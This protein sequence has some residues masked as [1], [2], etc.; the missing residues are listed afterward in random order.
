MNKFLDFISSKNFR[1]T[2]CFIV[3]TLIMAITISSQNYLFQKVLKNGMFTA[4]ISAKRDMKVIDV[5]KTEQ[6]KKKAMN[7][8][9]SC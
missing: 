7:L 1:N 9:V 8:A 6:L 5:V 3:F 4:D 2:F